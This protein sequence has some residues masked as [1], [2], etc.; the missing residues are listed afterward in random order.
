M[1]PILKMVGYP[2]IIVGETCSI[3]MI[4][5]YNT[6][7]NM[8]EIMITF[9]SIDVIQSQHSWPFQSRASSVQLQAPPVPIKTNA[10][11]SEAPAGEVNHARQLG[12]ATRRLSVNLGR[13]PQWT[14][15]VGDFPCLLRRQKKPLQ[16][17]QFVAL[18]CFFRVLFLGSWG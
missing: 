4:I 5:R 10:P 7:D 17:L 6:Y 11:A 12:K 8:Y 1:N 18:P 13:P 15:S 16:S 2:D 9:I 14:Q 3:H